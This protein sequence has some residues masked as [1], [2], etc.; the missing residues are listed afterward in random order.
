M[1]SRAILSVVVLSIIASCD[2]NPNSGD[3]NASVGKQRPVRHWRERDDLIAK[4]IG[5]NRREKRYPGLLSEDYAMKNKLFFDETGKLFWNEQLIDEPTLQD[6]LDRS[7]NMNPKADLIVRASTR[8]TP[9]Q[10]DSL[11]DKILDSVYC[12]AR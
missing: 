12:K 11:L 8:V 5:L 3:R 10:L 4:C 7:S 9:D 2:A 6:Y 1:L